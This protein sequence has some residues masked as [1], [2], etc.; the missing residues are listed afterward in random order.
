MHKMYTQEI[1]NKRTRRGGN[2]GKRRRNSDPIGETIVDG[3]ER[4]R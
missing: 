4:Y 1:D 3:R 2:Q